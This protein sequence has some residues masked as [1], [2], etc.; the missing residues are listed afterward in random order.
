MGIDKELIDKLLGDYK[1]PEIQ[2]LGH[3]KGTDFSVEGYELQLVHQIL[4]THRGL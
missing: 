1:G 2:V 3:L 4:P